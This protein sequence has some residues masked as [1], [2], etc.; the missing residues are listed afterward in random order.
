[1]IVKVSSRKTPR[2]LSLHVSKNPRKNVVVYG[3]A[4]SVSRSTRIIHSIVVRHIRGKFL[5]DCTCESFQF[6]RPEGGC[7]HIRAFKAKILAR[8]A[9]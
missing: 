7:I 1:M 6:A 3:T 5:F 2:I 4:E 8:K 9:A